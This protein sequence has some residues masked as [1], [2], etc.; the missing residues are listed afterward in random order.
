[1]SYFGA[2]NVNNATIRAGGKKP[3]ADGTIG[4]RFIVSEKTAMIAYGIY[5]VIQRACT[6]ECGVCP[7]PTILFEQVLFLLRLKVLEAVG[8]RFS[9]RLEVRFLSNGCSIQQVNVPGR[10]VPLPSSSTAFDEIRALSQP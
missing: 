1:M 4:A 3:T 7:N 9:A 10:V 2:P 6:P 5:P 8:S